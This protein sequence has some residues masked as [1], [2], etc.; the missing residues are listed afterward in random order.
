MHRQINVY[1]LKLKQI[2]DRMVGMKID[3]RL[4]RL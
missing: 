3:D 1:T 2:G 4:D